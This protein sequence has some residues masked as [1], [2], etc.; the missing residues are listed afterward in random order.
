MRVPATP[1]ALFKTALVAGNVSTL[2]RRVFHASQRLHGPSDAGGAG[3]GG[4]KPSEEGLSTSQDADLSVEPPASSEAS[5]G[6]TRSQG[7]SSLKSRQMRKHVAS[8]LPPVELPARFLEECVTIYDAKVQPRLPLALV[9][10]SKRS[11]TSRIYAPRKG[12]STK[13]ICL[14]LETYF[15][16]ALQILMLRSYHL[17]QE[18][19]SWPLI[20]G[21]GNFDLIGHTERMLR[22]SNMLIDT[23]WHIVDSILYEKMAEYT[24]KIRPF[25][26]W[27]IFDIYN[28]SWRESLHEITAPLYNSLCDHI[29]YAERLEHPLAHSTLDIPINTIVALQ[30]ALD[31]EL[32]AS[33]PPHFDHR[34]GKRP[35][36]IFFGAGYGGRAIS[37]ALSERLAFISQAN[38]VR[39]N[40]SS[41]SILL[42]EYL[43]Q[44]WAYA[45]GAVSNMGF[46]AAELNGKLSKEPEPP[47]RQ[48]DDDDDRDSNDVGIISFRPGSATVEEEL[49]RGKHASYDC[50]TKWENLK[51]DKVLDQ[52][53]RSPFLKSPSSSK[54]PVIIHV[55]DFV[56]LSMTLEGSL[57]LGKL[58]SLVDAAWQQGTK[59]AIFGTSSCEYPSD[60]YQ[61]AVKHLC[62]VDLVLSRNIQPAARDDKV[63]LD[64]DRPMGLQD[65]DYFFENIENVREMVGCMDK[66]LAKRPLHLSDQDLDSFLYT[67]HPRYANLKSTILP[68]PEVYNLAN[69][70]RG[71]ERISQGDG[72]HAFL[73]RM[74]LHPLRVKPNL[75]AANDVRE[76][77]RVES[78][79]SKPHKSTYDPKSNSSKAPN[80]NDYEKRIA[81]GIIDRNNLRTTFADIHLPPETIA[82][83]KLLTSL[84]L[85]RPDAFSYGVLAQDKITGCLFYGPPGTGKTMLAKAIAK[86]S[87][88]NMLE[89][90]GATINDKWVGES[91]KLIRAIFT[92][93]KR[94]SP[95]VVFIDE[96]DSI[97]AHRGLHHSRTSHRDHLNQF[98]KEWDGLEEST[99]FIM[100]ATNRPF[101]LDDAV[102]RRL[103]RK[104]MIDLPDVNG[105]A[106]ILRLMLKKEQVDASFS[107]DDYAARTPYYSGS[108]LKNLCITAAMLAVEEENRHAAEHK[109]PEPYKYP[110][111]RTLTPHHFEQ[112]LKQISAS[113]SEHMSSLRQLRHFD[114][115]YGSGRN[116]FKK[117]AFGFGGLPG[118]M[119]DKKTSQA[120]AVRPDSGP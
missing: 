26:W 99:A 62:A 81:H 16:T 83:V 35:I 39:L 41:L 6:R 53:I 86:E 112:A 9:E 2:T 103:P 66:D 55:H 10:D 64:E 24:Y 100:V 23:A 104:V 65:T 25:W 92:T 56:E 27:D 90:S 98:L 34:T 8:A 109:G 43:G 44:D 71:L 106:A 28:R 21:D 12:L 72:K 117:P 111:R 13:A 113:V 74:N 91:E 88:A 19:S 60:D 67:N 45:R 57:I 79:Y 93:A 73:E 70:Y 68:M 4:S 30:S 51:I 105:R 3:I 82:A 49:Q 96:A 22:I 77:A 110:V 108:D 11:K 48:N 114:E 17:A 118:A 85:V 63:L 46:R 115:Q 40:A 54:S 95:C 76:E 61:N 97:F 107:I 87:G 47:R 116:K 78:D 119:Q 120:P 75:T 69:A 31:H 33:P 7:A 1:R 37:E 94:L 89:I 38:L 50:F 52:I 20:Y 58:R 18:L 102:L 14:G 80:Q 84:S 29:Y 36:T 32:Q 15:D 59:I 5:G 42:G 101:D